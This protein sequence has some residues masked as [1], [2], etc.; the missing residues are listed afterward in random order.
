MK[1]LPVVGKQARQVDAAACVTV[2]KMT[3]KA[4][5]KRVSLLPRLHRLSA[6]CG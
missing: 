5:G 4:L 6:A 3:Q 2:E 1:T